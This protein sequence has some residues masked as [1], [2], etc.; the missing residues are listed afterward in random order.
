MDG[1]NRYCC[2]KCA[3]QN[4]ET[5]DRRAET[6]SKLS[7]EQLQ[8]W[9]NKRIDTIKKESG[10][11]ISAIDLASR[12]ARSVCH[13]KEYLNKCDCSFI[14]YD[15]KTKKVTFE[16]NKCH[17][18]E[19]FVRSLLDRYA[20]TNDYKI[21]HVCNSKYSS[22]PEQE[23]ADYIKSIYDGQV[24]SRDRHL[25]NGVELDIVIPEKKIAIEFDGLYW[26][27]ENVVSWDSHVNKTNAC[28]KLD[29][30]LVHIFEDEW[31]DKKEIV[32]SRIS[33]L[34]GKN[35][36]IFARKCE[37]GQLDSS[38]TTDFLNECHIQ[39]ACSSKF[40][41]GLY[42]N[43]ELV[44]VMTFG[45]SRFAKNEFEL[46]RFCNRLYTN[47]VGGASRLLSHFLEDHQEIKTLISY[48][49]RRW[50]KGN[51]YEAIGFKKVHITDPAYFYIVN[52]VRE[53]R[54][55]YQKHKLI[56]A[57]ADPDKTE[58]EIMKERGYL[59]IFDCGTIKYQFVA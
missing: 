12:N 27:N 52:S 26:H 36:R 21:C 30:Q 23:I 13:F 57:G 41:Y 9:R 20:R 35:D 14:L 7:I 19:T 39:G 58:Y 46:L 5:K 47:V 3:W 32:K 43:D 45:K 50:S 48:A 8:A 1:Y 56:A 40:H 6:L 38:T 15:T 2:R 33:G 29:Y 24:L 16:C 34:L 11:G 18:T 53:N 42:Y 4:Q 25:L 49:D 55:K 28:E 59:R 10:R 22:K 37:V 44:S 54:V 17:T 31:R 51:L